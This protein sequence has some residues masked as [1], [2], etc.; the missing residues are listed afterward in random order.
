[1]GTR[2]A[3][4]V[5]R[6]QAAAAD[7]SLDAWCARLRIELLVIFGSAADSARADAARDLDVAVLLGADG[8]LLEVIDALVELTGCP[9][10]DLLDLGRAGPVVSEEALVGTLPLY[11]AESGLLTQLRDRAMVRRMDTAWLRRLDLDLMASG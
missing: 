5:A 6:L 2:P 3:Q 4:A 10:V 11:E 7:G 8:G 9:D 1:M